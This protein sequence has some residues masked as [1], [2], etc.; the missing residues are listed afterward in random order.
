M[1]RIS[2][3]ITTTIVFIALLV[4]SASANTEIRNFDAPMSGFAITKDE[5]RTFETQLG[6][7]GGEMVKV[8]RTGDGENLLNVRALRKE[9]ER[10]SEVESALWL[11]LELDTSAK[12]T[13]RVSWP[14]FVSCC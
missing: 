14:A 5:Q 2:S 3:V 8:L 13:I 6:Q 1:R 9:T 4:L 10:E 7:R 12:H 11:K